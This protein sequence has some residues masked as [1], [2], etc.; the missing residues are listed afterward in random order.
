METTVNEPRD[1]ETKL[2]PRAV[3][4]SGSQDVISRM[5][6][7][8]SCTEYEN[9]ENDKRTGGSR[10][11][12]AIREL[13]VA[14]FDAVER[15]DRRLRESI[16]SRGC[17]LEMMESPVC[18]ICADLR[19]FVRRSTELCLCLLDRPRPGPGYA[20]I[21]RARRDVRGPSGGHFRCASDVREIES[22]RD[23]EREKKRERLS[24]YDLRRIKL[25]EVSRRRCIFTRWFATRL[26]LSR[27][28]T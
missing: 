4:R 19:D 11:E 20:I 18:A 7:G 6:I 8:P 17:S 2:W 14:G 3:E 1:N 24:Q 15:R 9:R 25:P 16:A 23:R 22:E 28:I 21:L 26:S 12:A 13:R 27:R 10:N 5:R